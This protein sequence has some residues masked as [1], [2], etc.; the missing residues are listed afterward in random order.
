MIQLTRENCANPAVWRG[1]FIKAI[2]ELRKLER[3][4]P[5]SSSERD[6]IYLDR[7]HG[8]NGA[9][10]YFAQMAYTGDIDS[11]FYPPMIKVAERLNNLIRKYY[12]R[13]SQRGVST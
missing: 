8:E 12:D 10:I 1:R 6:V 4:F 2:R 13:K 9:A 7:L 11:R 3:D 5:D